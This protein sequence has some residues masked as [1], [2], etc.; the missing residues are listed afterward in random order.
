MLIPHARTVRTSTKGGR[1]RCPNPP[2]RPAHGKALA[3]RQGRAGAAPETAGWFWA[4][5]SARPAPAVWRWVTGQHTLA[6]VLAQGRPSRRQAL[7]R[8]RRGAEWRVGARRPC[9]RACG[10]IAFH[11]CTHPVRTP[12]TFWAPSP[13][14]IHGLLLVVGA[15]VH[16]VHLQPRTVPCAP[17]CS[18]WVKTEVVDPSASTCSSVDEAR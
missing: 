16:S 6:V 14:R 13:S 9:R 17:S 5:W 7:W 11:A 2:S 12:C 10:S 1:T 15:H 4:C 8:Q 18:Q 3:C